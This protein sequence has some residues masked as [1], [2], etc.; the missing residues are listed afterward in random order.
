ME[1]PYISCAIELLKSLAAYDYKIYKP[2]VFK[3]LEDNNLSHEN[4]IIFLS[5][6]LEKGETESKIIAYK[7]RDKKLI[8]P[9]NPA[10]IKPENIVYFD[11]KE[12][13]KKVEEREECHYAL[14]V[15]LSD[16]EIAFEEN[17]FL[18]I[19]A[20]KT[21]ELKGS[22]QIADEDIEE[23]FKNLPL[24]K[25][26]F[27]VD[28][29]ILKILNE[30]FYKPFYK[31]FSEATALLV[32]TYLFWSLLSGEFILFLDTYREL[33][34]STLEGSGSN[35]NKDEIDDRP[36]PI[37]LKERYNIYLELKR[38]IVQVKAILNSVKASCLFVSDDM[39]DINAVNRNQFSSLLNDL[40]RLYRLSLQMTVIDLR[41]YANED[42]IQVLI[43]ILNCV[44]RIK[45][46]YE[47]KDIPLGFNLFKT[48]EPDIYSSFKY[49]L[50]SLEFKA[51]VLLNGILNQ[52][53]DR[54]VK[55][56]THLYKIGNNKIEKILAKVQYK[57]RLNLDPLLKFYQNS[58]LEIKEENISFTLYD[59]YI[60]TNNS[61][62]FGL[63]ASLKND[64]ERLFDRIKNLLEDKFLQ[65][66]PSFFI[67]A[68]K[69]IQHC[70]DKKIKKENW[71]AL[72]CFALQ[73][74]RHYLQFY[75]DNECIPAQFRRCFAHSFMKKD[76]EWV[77]CELSREAIENHRKGCSL[78]S[79]I[80]FASYGYAPIDIQYLE[81]FFFEYNNGWHLRQEKRFQEQ[82]VSLYKYE[83]ILEETQNLQKNTKEY[84]NEQFSDE[85]KR[86]IQLLGIFGALL[87]FVSSVVGLQ[88]VV[89]TPIE[90]VLFALMFT[91]SLLIFVVAIHHISFRQM[92]LEKQG[93]KDTQEQEKQKKK[94][95]VLSQV[96]H[97]IWVVIVGLV[98]A[99]AG[100]AL[101]YLGNYDRLKGNHERSA[102][103]SDID[104]NHEHNVQHR[105]Q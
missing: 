15:D 3:L 11:S 93:N 62:Y 10:E 64:K 101:I 29:C 81:N 56:Y 37:I 71:N 67:V 65:Y 36:V 32:Y 8:P 105:Q 85:R 30:D 83:K 59:N 7:D 47:R 9:F 13:I 68:L 43:D 70:V 25:M 4:Q 75:R 79:E 53:K 66:P 80:F 86:T 72:L 84:V 54:R 22:K 90:F 5:K 73:K 1:S 60:Q 102:I 89:T 20:A 87:A 50:D 33:F 99:L 45:I 14:L 48:W 41:Y 28:F 51:S 97:P 44:H 38:F 18:H 23:I 16:K 63:L 39:R 17:N 74:L 88:K 2:I 19:L 82:M 96:W 91:T 78:I 104:I 12:E 100:V 92:E 35:M 61:V 31:T 34:K 103:S 49:V 24:D 27:L 76:D 57:P 58:D 94:K 98:L 46:E 77:S 52:E 42:N 69:I 55:S 40:F 21:I 26:K 6:L 95:Q